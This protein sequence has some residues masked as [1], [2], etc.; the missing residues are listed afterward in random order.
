MVL[1]AGDR[2]VPRPIHDEIRHQEARE[3]V[4]GCRLHQDSERMLKF[5]TILL[6]GTVFRDHYIDIII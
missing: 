2:R 3:H 4:A 5:C 6:Q 1:R